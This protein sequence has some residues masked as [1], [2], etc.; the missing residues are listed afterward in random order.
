MSTS[1]A[2]KF[3]QKHVGVFE[4]IYFDYFQKKSSAILLI[5]N[6]FEIV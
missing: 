5:L 2:I 1:L 4:K 6:L 3:E